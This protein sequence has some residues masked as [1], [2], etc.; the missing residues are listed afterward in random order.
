MQD[1][2][3]III[4][5]GINGCGIAK[6]A[7]Q[8]GLKTYLCE[9][10]DLASATSSYSSKLIHGGLRY[11]EN[12]D[13]SLV[14][15][16]LQERENLLKIAPHLIEPLEFIMPHGHTM[17]SAWLIQ[18]G[19][20]LYDH[21][22]RRN[23]LPGSKKLKLTNTLFGEPLKA[24]YT[25]GFSYY[26]C[27]TDDA[28]LV[29]ENAKSAKAAG[30]KIETRTI[31]QK[32]SY[33]NHLWHIETRHAHTN[34]INKLSS[35][36]IINASGPWLDKII[37]KAKNTTDTQSIQLVKGSHIITPKLYEGAHAYILQNSDKRIIFVIPFE[38]H[39]SL[40]G[41]TDIPFN[42]EPHE[43]QITEDEINYLLRCINR[44]FKYNLKTCDIIHSFSGVRALQQNKAQENVSKSSRDYQLQWLTSKNRGFL[45]IIGGKITTHRKLS[46]EAVNK[47]AHYLKIKEPSVSLKTRLSGSDFDGMSKAEYFLQLSQKYSA[48]PQTLLQRLF[49]LYGSNTEIILSNANSTADLGFYFGHD[50]YEAEL[51]YLIQ[52]EW[53]ETLED[54]L[55]RRTK[56]G[57]VF[58]NNEC[59]VL[60]NFLKE[61]FLK[62]NFE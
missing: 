41:T 53:A 29:I 6:E 44:Y 52:F 43:A 13:F 33:N 51:N 35:K 18:L 28:R 9:K 47:I 25:K 32:I 22:A 5:G 24:E 46:V 19:L 27:Y 48:L 23:T 15:H 56:L 45:N 30:A 55:W 50:F 57:L 39:Y 11:L 36:V 26:D 3:V 16:A 12:Y 20:F 1:Y 37:H 4:G 42:H 14:R 34:K 58:Q 2:D 38:N 61:F 17:R 49:K 7:A 62:D 54:I 31:C 21:L 10:N 59:E 40:I 60:K 8:R